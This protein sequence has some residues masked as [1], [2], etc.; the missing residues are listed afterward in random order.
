MVPHAPARQ[1]TSQAHEDEQLTSPHALVVVH[2]TVH[3]PFAQVTFWHAPEA[4]QLK[5]HG[6]PAAHL[7]SPHEFVVAQVIAHDLEVAEHTVPLHA[8]WAEHWMLHA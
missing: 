7:R 8:F 5:V 4:L 6:T 1:V 2:L 3:A